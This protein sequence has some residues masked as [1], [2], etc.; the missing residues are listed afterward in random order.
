MHQIVLILHA[1]NLADSA[2]LRDLRGRDVAQP[3]VTHQALTLELGQNG[4]WRFDRPFGR[5]MHVEHAAKVDHVEHIEAEI[6]KVV[7]HRL[8]EFRRG[9]G[10]NP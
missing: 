6:A 2:T 4:E 1:D 5:S 3:D 10:R 9:E 8:G 7:V